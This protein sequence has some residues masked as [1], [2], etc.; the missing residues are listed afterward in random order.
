MPILL[1]PNIK[2]KSRVILFF[3]EPCQDLG[4][5]AYRTIGTR[6]IKQG[7]IE[8]FVAGVFDGMSNASGNAEVPGVLIANPGQLLWHRGGQRPLTL[9]SWQGLPRK[10]AVHDAMRLDP[11]KNRI[12][13]NE[14]LEKHVAYVFERVLD[15]VTNAQAQI[16]VIALEWSAD[17]IV[18]YLNTNCK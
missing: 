9:S 18:K 1:S 6:S 16:D 5:L 3:N 17:A 14:S 10:T 15:S 13:G 7:S 12:P 2:T 11:V 8:E 4:I